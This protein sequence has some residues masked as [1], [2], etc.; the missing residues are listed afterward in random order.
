MLLNVAHVSERPSWG[1]GSVNE[2][3]TTRQRSEPQVCEPDSACGV[4]YVQ[5]DGAC[6][7]SDPR[8]GSGHYG[9][10]DKLQKKRDR[11]GH[12][13]WMNGSE[14]LGNVHRQLERPSAEDA[15]E[16]VHNKKMMQMLQI[17]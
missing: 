8:C 6:R 12:S 13:N 7:S 15:E 14:I 11:D 16:R 10:N 17:K 3:P 1:G 4:C 2:Q 5:N 9:C